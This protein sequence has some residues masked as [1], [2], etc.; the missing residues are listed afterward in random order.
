M[1]LLAGIYYPGG[2]I[3]APHMPKLAAKAEDNA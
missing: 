2:Y 1:V 3:E